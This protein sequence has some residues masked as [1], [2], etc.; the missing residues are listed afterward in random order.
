[1]TLLAIVLF[2]SL[3]ALVFTFAGYPLVL[4]AWSRLAPRPVRTAPFE[5]EVTMVIVAH[6]AAGAIGRKVANCLAQ[7]Y[8]RD[9]LRV[10]VAS[11]G[12]D[13]ATE[14]EVA[15]LGDARASVLAFPGRRGK[16]ACLNDALAACRTEF[17]VL[18]DVRQ[19]LDPSA[20][21]CLMENL[22]DPEVGAASGQ[23][24]FLREG[25]TGVGE[26]LD[27]YWRYEKLIRRDES[28]IHSSV[29]VTGALYA[30][31]RECFR[32]IPPQT[33][34]D[35][36]NRRLA[37]DCER[38]VAH[39]G[40][41]QGGE[42]QRRAAGSSSRDHEGAAPH[43]FCKRRGLPQHA[44]AE[45][46]PRGGGKLKTHIKS[47]TASCLFSVR[48]RVNRRFPGRRPGP[49]FPQPKWATPAAVVPWSISRWPPPGNAR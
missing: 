7:D 4:A 38:R 43:S 23:L 9:R 49:E 28:T 40:S 35:E 17:V 39:A 24:V 47:R 45:E 11:D 20:V 18:A 34:L 46:N 1:M 29:G 48:S 21:R 26:S 41:G 44:G 19:A 22:A 2:G 8:P 33:V 32:P 27:A 3:A 12:S 25:I 6:N 10:L 36:S 13:D 37:T 15:G 14:H 16:A 30:L 42:Q 31:R 5:P